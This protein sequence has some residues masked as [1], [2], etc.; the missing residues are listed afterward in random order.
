MMTDAKI[1]NFIE[2]YFKKYNNENFAIWDYYIL[3]HENGE[4]TTL[5]VYYHT[6]DGNGVVKEYTEHVIKIPYTDIMK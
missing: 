6:W 5:N 3:R 2:T 1:I 4:F